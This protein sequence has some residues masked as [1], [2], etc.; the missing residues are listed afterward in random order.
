MHT[1]TT[2]IAIIA[3]AKK[4]VLYAF[5]CLYAKKDIPESAAILIPTNSSPT[6]RSDR[7]FFV[8]LSLTSKTKITG[9]LA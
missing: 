3:S 6:A 9:L 2:S 7:D 4:S 1:V 5:G 8:L